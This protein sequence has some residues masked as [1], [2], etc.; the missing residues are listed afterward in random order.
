MVCGYNKAIIV[1]VDKME[2][3]MA[4]DINTDVDN[5]YTSQQREVPLISAHMIPGTGFKFMLEFYDSQLVYLRTIK[6]G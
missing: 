6:T 4:I 3:L 1:D 2:Q 5:S